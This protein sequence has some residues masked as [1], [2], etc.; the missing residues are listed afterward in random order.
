VFAGGNARGDDV[1]LVPGAKVEHAVGTRVIGQIQSESPSEVVVQI[2]GGSTT[3]NVP[4]DKIASIRYSGESAQ[5]PLADSRE[6][7]GQL[8]EAAELFKKAAAESEGKPY[9]HQAAL[10]REA[11]ALTD[12]ALIEPEKLKD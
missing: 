9:L 2:G 12:L 6:N 8:A 1:F 5:F 10:F 4:T 3:A 11:R 7:A